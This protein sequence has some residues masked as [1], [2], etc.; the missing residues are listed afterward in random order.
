MILLNSEIKGIIFGK[1]GKK[2]KRSCYLH[3]EVMIHQIMG[4]MQGQAADL[5]ISY[6]RIE[7]K[8][9]SLNDIMAK[10]TG[11]KYEKIAA[12]T[13][14]DYFMTAEEALKYGIIDYIKK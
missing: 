11:Q 7:K 14:R 2:G 12:D 9:H 5:E 6:K 1:G 4:G 13:E 10:N 8:K 3:S